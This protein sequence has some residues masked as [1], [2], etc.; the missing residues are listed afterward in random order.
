M[1]LSDKS[2]SHK[3]NVEDCSGLFKYEMSKTKLET[4]YKVTNTS[5]NTL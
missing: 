4:K 5:K 3:S 1:Q 2:L